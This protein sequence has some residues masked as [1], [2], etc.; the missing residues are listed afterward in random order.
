MK[1]LKCNDLGGPCGQKISA[2]S[3]EEMGQKCFEHIM[4]Q[5]RNGDEAHEA[6]VAKIR[7]VS[8]QQRETMMAEFLKKYND[9]PEE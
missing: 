9:A 3:F 6:A 7:H 5:I 8:P 4:E 1:T 2:D